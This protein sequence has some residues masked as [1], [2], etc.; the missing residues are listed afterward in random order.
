[1]NKKSI[2]IGVLLISF[3]TLFCDN[4]NIVLQKLFQKYE[5]INSYKADFRQINFWNELEIEKESI[6]IMRYND[7]K[8]ILRYSEP[9]GQ[10]LYIDNDKMIIYDANSKQV[11]ISDLNYIVSEIRPI[12]IIQYYSKK[13]E[14]S[15]E[16]NKM[17][18]NVKNDDFI[19]LIE[20]EYSSY[21]EIKNLKYYD[22]DNN[23]VSYNFRNIEI[24]LEMKEELF[25][26]NFPEDA[27]IIDNRR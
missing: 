3:L 1:M 15:I 9:D 11:M 26:V 14:I 24:N 18:M 23:T 21:F 25:D 20:V 5:T 7:D 10:C 8:L 27:S 12:K 13:S 17:I 19:R 4:S 6:G 22:Y 2:M 16:A